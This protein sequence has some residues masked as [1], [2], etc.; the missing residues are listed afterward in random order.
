[1]VVFWPA[2]PGSIA[3]DTPVAVMV[4]SPAGEPAAGGPTSFTYEGPII[5]EYG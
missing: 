3:V 4:E 1:M 5:E 2:D